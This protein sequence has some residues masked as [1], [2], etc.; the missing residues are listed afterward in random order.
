M[1]LAAF[2]EIYS[3]NE[4][5]E[6]TDIDFLNERLSWKLPEE[7]ECLY[8]QANGFGGQVKVV[9]GALGY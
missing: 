3:R 8:F 1:E 2:D 6:K 4:G 9:C 7:F 5:V